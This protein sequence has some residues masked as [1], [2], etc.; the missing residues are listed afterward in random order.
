MWFLFQEPSV[1]RT[2]LDCGKTDRVSSPGEPH[3]EALAEPHVNV[4]AH[5]A[6]IIQPG[7]VHQVASVQTARVGIWLPAR[8]KVALHCNPVIHRTIGF[9]TTPCSVQY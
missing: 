3:P 6:P 9:F 4:S 8:A 7:R 5:T 2:S 1:L